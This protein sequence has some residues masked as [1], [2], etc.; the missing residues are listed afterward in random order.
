ML[1][2]SSSNKDPTRHLQEPTFTIS[3]KYLTL[4]R[5]SIVVA[6]APLY[7]STQHF[8]HHHF[9]GAC[10][11]RLRPWGPIQT[12]PSAGIL[13]EGFVFLRP[14]AHLYVQGRPTHIATESP[15]HVIVDVQLGMGRPKAIAETAAVQSRVK[16][17][18]DRHTRRATCR[19][20]CC[21]QQVKARR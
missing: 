20:S 11:G 6:S 7:S 21:E 16:A 13:D 2:S 12:K 5:K 1:R 4:Q 10:A 14:V 18:S 19:Q 9:K 15:A 8:T 3:S 17:T